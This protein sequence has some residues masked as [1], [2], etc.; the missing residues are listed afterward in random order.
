[1]SFRILLLLV[2]LGLN[3]GEAAEQKL[4]D[5]HQVVISRSPLDVQKA[6]AEELTNYVHQ[7]TGNSLNIISAREYNKEPGLSFFVGDQV[8]AECL[9]IN[10]APWKNEEWA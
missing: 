9:G 7:I 2:L 3:Y 8:A 6:A 5:F 10:L 4:S 1:M